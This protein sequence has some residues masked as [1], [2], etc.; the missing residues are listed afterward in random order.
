MTATE[1]LE[2]LV[3]QDLSGVVFVRDYLQ[4]QFNP[5]PTL[6]V[7]SRC[8]INSGGNRLTF[9]EPPFANAAI[10]QIGKYVTRAVESEQALVLWFADGSSVEIPISD[11]SF[12]GPEASALF[13]A[14]G[15]L[16]EWPA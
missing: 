4:F 10:A 9:G 2:Q 15:E 8:V 14:G 7:Y 3:G 13:G 5:P 16:Y 11:G 6:N 1:L 12:Q